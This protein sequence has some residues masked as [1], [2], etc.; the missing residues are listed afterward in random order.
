LLP[1]FDIDIVVIDETSMLE[2]YL[3]DLIEQNHPNVIFIFIGDRKQLPPVGEKISPVFTKNWRTFDLTKIIRQGV[4]NPIIDLSRDLNRLYSRQDNLVEINGTLSGYLF[5]SD[6]D[7][8]IQQLAIVNGTDDLKYLAYTNKVVD[9]V[10]NA[11][12]RLIY[13]ANPNKIQLGETLIMNSPWGEY[14]TNKEI[15]VTS[16]E[17]VERTL[18]IPNEDSKI[19]ETDNGLIL[20]NPYEYR[21][22][23]QV[24]NPDGTPKMNCGVLKVK[25]YLINES[26]PVIHEH[27]EREFKTIYGEI[28]AKCNARIHNVTFK[29]YFIEQVADVGYNHALTVHKSQGSTYKKVVMNFPN[30]LTNRS[31]TEREKMLYTAVTRPANLLIVHV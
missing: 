5:T 20:A 13:G 10:N 23:E 1:F 22:E 2:K 19:H 9:S 11:V 15:K 12:R 4:G 3:I 7:Y 30:I 18:F 21:G 14:H 6:W 26:M 16:L 8:I 27:S 17:V 29:H 25:V 24:M 31:A 28:E